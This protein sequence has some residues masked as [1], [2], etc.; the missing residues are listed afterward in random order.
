[1]AIPPLQMRGGERTRRYQA[2]VFPRLAGLI[3]AVGPDI[4][5]DAGD[6]LPAIAGGEPG[7]AWLSEMVYT[8]WVPGKH[9]A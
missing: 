9:D 4:L 5:I 1:M 2:R 3:R 6:T 7:L 8:A